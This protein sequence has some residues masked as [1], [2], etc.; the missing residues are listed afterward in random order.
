MKLYDT[1]L[2]PNPR[3]VR[4]FMAE[5]GI[6]DIEIVA[7]DLEGPG[8]TVGAPPPPGAFRAVETILGSTKPSMAG[9]MNAIFSL[10]LSQEG[11]IILEETFKQG[12]R[13]VGV[14]G[15]FKY[16]ALRP[17]LDVEIK[18]N[19]KRIYDHLSMGIDLTAG[20]PIGGV[21]VYLDVGLDF[22]FEVPICGGDNARRDLNRTIA[23]NACDLSIFKHA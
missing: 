19:F 21:P 8:G 1:P 22:A 23:A 9:D 12:G 3:R 14:V 18:A 10:V 11:A 7:L 13:P 2:A 6:D 20:V 17:A 15:D 4:W 16:T 5:K